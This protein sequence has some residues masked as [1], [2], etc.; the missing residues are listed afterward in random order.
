MSTLRDN[1]SVKIHGF[2]FHVVPKFS[3][4]GYSG[5]SYTKYDLAKFDLIQ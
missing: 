3:L 5:R 1:V 4:P 2:L